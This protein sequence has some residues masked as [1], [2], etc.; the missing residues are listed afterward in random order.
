MLSREYSPTF[1]ARNVERPRRCPQRV[2]MAH[3]LNVRCYWKA[4][5][6]HG[7][8]TGPKATIQSAHPAAVPMRVAGSVTHRLGSLMT[9]HVS[10]ISKVTDVMPSSNSP[11]HPN[12][13]AAFCS[14]K[15]GGARRCPERRT[16]TLTT[17]NGTATANLEA[18][19]MARAKGHTESGH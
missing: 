17:L 18:A 19:A 11:D 12:A 3:C 6:P 8:R 1:H 5:G 7:N 4:D 15:A 13:S 2:E 16:K 10:T 14:S 9:S